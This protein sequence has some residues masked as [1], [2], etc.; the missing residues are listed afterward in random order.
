MHKRRT[1]T[2]IKV[3]L[4]RAHRD[5]RVGNVQSIESREG[6]LPSVSYKRIALSK[7][8]APFNRVLFCKALTGIADLSF[9]LDLIN[10]AICLISLAELM[11]IAIASAA[12]TDSIV[13]LGLAGGVRKSSASRPSGNPFITLSERRLKASS[14]SVP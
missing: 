12:T 10:R 3:I 2:I 8:E 1:H 4:R 7:V 13:K 5:L 6:G 9:R 11:V 14:T